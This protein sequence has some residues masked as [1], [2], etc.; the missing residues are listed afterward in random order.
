MRALP[1]LGLHA[2][3]T[4]VRRPRTLQVT[5]EAPALTLGSAVIMTHVSALMEMSFLYERLNFFIPSL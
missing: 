1:R 2:I 3:Q 5:S 4:A